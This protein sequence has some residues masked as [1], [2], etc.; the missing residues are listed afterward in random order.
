[1]PLPHRCDESCACPVHGTPLIYW[2]YGN[3]HAC[4]EPGCP[5][6]HGLVQG[7]WDAISSLPP[8]SDTTCRLAEAGGARP[9]TRARRT[10]AGPGRNA[11]MD[12]RKD[13]P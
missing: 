6:Y 4:T 10:A 2:P 9:R 8:C 1:M 5:H 12:A 13:E 3:D 7:L 11:W